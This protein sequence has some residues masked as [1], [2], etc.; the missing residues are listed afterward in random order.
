MSDPKDLKK[1]LVQL[2]EPVMKLRALVVAMDEITSETKDV[3]TNTLAKMGV[4]LAYEVEEILAKSGLALN[5]EAST[6]VL[7]DLEEPQVA[8]IETGET[9][10][11]G[12]TSLSETYAE[13]RAARTDL[14]EILSKRPRPTSPESK[15]HFTALYDR[16]DELERAILET[17]DAD[18]AHDLAVKLVVAL[19]SEE[20][21]AVETPHG[22]IGRVHR[23]AL[24]IIV[25]AG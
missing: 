15:A 20:P 10:E 1:T 21:S 5:Y 13:W 17:P 22:Y 24:G 4:T 16:V 3:T 8:P 7:S 14:R 2:K 25:R 23:E 18:N 19:E 9:G 12:Q 11:T 6:F